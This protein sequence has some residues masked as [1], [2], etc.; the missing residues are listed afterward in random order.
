MAMQIKL[1]VVVVVVVV[2]V[3][4]SFSI[5]QLNLVICL[6]ARLRFSS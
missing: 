5:K 6:Q 4:I 2:V 3:I 1:F